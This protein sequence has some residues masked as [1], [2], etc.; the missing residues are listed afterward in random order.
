MIGKY[1]YLQIAPANIIKK[2]K[3]GNRNIIITNNL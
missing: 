2:Q 1:N 3:T